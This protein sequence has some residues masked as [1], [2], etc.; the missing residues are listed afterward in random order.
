M[1]YSCGKFG[2]CILNRFGSI[3]LNVFGYYRTER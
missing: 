2:D 1:D 3:T